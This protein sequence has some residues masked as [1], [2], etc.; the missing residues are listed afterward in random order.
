MEKKYP[1]G[2]YA[3]GNYQ[4]K[5]CICGNQFTG[6]KRAVQCEPCAEKAVSEGTNNYPGSEYQSLF[7]Y[8][9]KEHQLMLLQS[10]M[11]D[12]IDMVHKFHPKTP[13][14][15][16]SAVWVNL[17]DNFTEDWE[18]MHCRYALDKYKLDTDLFELKDGG[19]VKKGGT[20]RVGL[21]EVE[22]L[23]EGEMLPTVAGVVWVK[24]TGENMRRSA[25]LRDSVLPENHI[26]QWRVNGW[27]GK[28]VMFT[29]GILKEWWELEILDD[30]TAVNTVEH[31]Q[32][33]KLTDMDAPAFT[34]T[35]EFAAHFSYI[36]GRLI[37]LLGGN[38]I[39]PAPYPEEA[40]LISGAPTI[41]GTYFAVIK[42]YINDDPQMCVLHYQAHKNIYKA[43]GHAFNIEVKTEDIVGY[44]GEIKEQRGADI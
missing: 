39:P 35:K 16:A 9:S 10:E 2:G 19:L 13:A 3:P 12:L 43:A 40:S 4:C 34:H 14:T 17:A 31:L 42:D 1:I 23:I 25:I 41:T 32:Q 37:E 7:E 11:G 20:G 28:G 38:K 21:R 27:D 24:A 18:M 44:V 5:C 22:Y 8:L 30:R 36:K 6:N 26:H 33:I 15:Q 29:N